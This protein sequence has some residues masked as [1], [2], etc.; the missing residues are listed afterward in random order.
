MKQ[1]I[2]TT[3]M[4]LL[5]VCSQSFAG[6][7]DDWFDNSVSSGPSTFQ[8]QQRG[9]YS[10]GSFTARLNTDVVRPITI[11][12]PKVKVGCA[13][14]D[15]RLGGVG[16]ADPDYLVDKVQTL[17]QSAPV[18]LYDVA[19]KQFSEQLSSSLGGWEKIMNELN[20]MQLSQCGMYN[21]VVSVA[22]SDDPSFKEVVKGL[23]T[24]IG[25]EKLT[26]DGIA[27]MFQEAQDEARDN[28]DDSPTGG[29]GETIADLTKGCTG[30]LLDMF[31]DGSFLKNV[32]EDTNMEDSVNVI[33]AYMGDV[34][35]KTAS[36]GIIQGVP[37]SSCM[38]ANGG[39]T[40]DLLFAKMLEKNFPSNPAEA[41]CRDHDSPGVYAEVDANLRGIITKIKGGDVLSAQEIAF[42]NQVRLPVFTYLRSAVKQNR[43]EE[44]LNILL[45]VSS[46]LLGYQMF[47]D[48][49]RLTGK[50]LREAA[51]ELRR[52]NS[53]H[54]DA[55]RPELFEE[56]V[57]EFRKLMI[58]AKNES[59]KLKE[60]FNQDTILLNALLNMEMH[61]RHVTLGHRRE[62]QNRV[63]SNS[64]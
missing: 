21:R 40:E 59:N 52:Q 41:Q 47:E 17:I 53:S 27:R 51:I 36:D 23:R 1:L 12:K 55:C 34:L 39:S 61:H 54:V 63:I 56:P 18:I 31:K 3:P 9:Y 33:R 46:S 62:K 13:G 25:A 48:L 11:T 10:L 60:T 38:V 8:S 22:T 7:V 20:G 4:V 14:I 57:A 35:I 19:L 42:I 64:R 16:W 28:N 30:R 15:L 2:R 50:H 37:I 44:V 32:L 43:E 58:R 29:D 6:W 26:R 45:T 49:Y 5:L 24:E